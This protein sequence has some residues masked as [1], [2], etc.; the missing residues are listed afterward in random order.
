MPQPAGERYNERRA[1]A[2]AA[3]C[4]EHRCKASMSIM[5]PM[6]YIRDVEEAVQAADS[7][8]KFTQAGIYPSSGQC[9]NSTDTQ[10]VAFTVSVA[11]ADI[12]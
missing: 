6:V 2:P 11:F 10:S 3:D 4:S 1:I 5:L 12:D 7:A 9:I 8:I